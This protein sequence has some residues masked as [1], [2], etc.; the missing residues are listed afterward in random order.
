MHLSNIT[1]AAVTV[2]GL[3]LG[4]LA[5]AQQVVATGDK[6]E[7][8]L[9][10]GKLSRFGATKSSIPILET[11]RSI[12]VIDERAFREF[13]ALTVDDTLAYTSGVIGDSFGFSTRG[14]FA[15]VRGF[16]AAEYRDGQQV[17]FGYYNNTRSDVYFLEQVEVLKGPASVLYG[18]GTPGGIVNAIS[19]LAG[20]GHQNEVIVEGGSHSRRQLAA[21]FNVELADSLYGRAVVLYRDSDTQVDHVNDN[22][23]GFMPSIT[24]RNERTSITAMVEYMDRESDTAHQFLPIDATGCLSGD[25]D[26]SPTSFCANKGVRELDASAYMGHPDFNRYDSKST[27]GSVLAS[28]RINDQLEVEG[29]VRYKD[30]EVDYRQAWVNFNGSGVPR[31][32]DAAGNTSRTYYL[33]ASGTRQWAVDLRARWNFVTGALRHEVVGGI[34]YQDVVTDQDTTYAWGADSFNIYDRSN[35]AIPVAFQSGQPASNSPAS[36]S[37]DEGVYFSDQV[38]IY[39]WKFN[40]GVRYDDTRSGPEGGDRQTDYALSGSAGILYAF[41]SGVS[42][43][44]SY[45]ESFEPVLGIDAITF[46]PYQPRE[47]ELLEAGIKYQPPGASTYITLAWFDIEENNQSNPAS[48]PGAASQQ[49]GVATSEGVEIEAFTR[50]GAFTFEV[51]ITVMDTENPDGDPFSSI[52]EQQ[53]STWVGYRPEGGVLYGFKSG[54]GA[55]YVSENESHDVANDVHV[56]TDGYTVF[57]AM[58]GYELDHWD[59]TLNLRN[60]TDEQYYSTCLARGDCFPGEER[61]VVARAA[62]RF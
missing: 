3:M 26:I 6:L 22:A 38:S 59:L 15:K 12:S 58:L 53:V 16:N 49:E 55:R 11:A 27:L 8:T 40:I 29:V 2:A 1:T 23:V 50:L 62:Y 39:N 33:A 4:S 14:D 36:L 35:G 28:H 46:D 21:D 5:A 43:Y 56:T 10:T 41:E 19:K 45:A 61:S 37:T 30:A 7:E 52:P 48:L 42:P 34:A 32:A 44:I 47:G 18:K 60:L 20:P 24:F 54:I 9:V 51:N 25:V 17:L 31:I 57:D 13:G